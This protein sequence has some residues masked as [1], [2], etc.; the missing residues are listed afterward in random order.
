MILD[1]KKGDVLKKM[2]PSKRDETLTKIAVKFSMS[3]NPLMQIFHICKSS[4]FFYIFSNKYGLFFVLRVAS[5]K[6]NNI[7][8]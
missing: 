5:C 7:S 6:K 1:K 4:F 2:K 3:E 8:D